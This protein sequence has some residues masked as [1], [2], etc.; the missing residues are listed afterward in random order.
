MLYPKNV[1]T[2]ERIGRIIFGIVLIGIGLWK[3]ST[4]SA[5]ALLVT[6][7]LVSTAVFIMGTGFIGW[8]PAC[9]MLGRK[10]KQKEP[11]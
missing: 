9:A 2:L 4:G 1:P 10:L 8:C 11:R 3:L 6:G 5:D 7:L